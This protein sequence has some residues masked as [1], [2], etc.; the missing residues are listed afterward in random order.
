[1]IEIQDLRGLA[2]AAS[3]YNREDTRHAVQKILTPV[4]SRLS[5][6][7][8]AQ[9]VELDGYVKAVQSIQEQREEHRKVNRELRNRMD[10]L[11]A[12]ARELQEQLANQAA[13]LELEVKDKITLE[14]RAVDL[15]SHRDTLAATIEQIKMSRSWRWTSS[16]RRLGNLKLRGSVKLSAYWSRIRVRSILIYHRLSIRNPRLAWS[17]RRM[18]RPAFRIA[19]R[20]FSHPVTMD[21][22]D[23][24]AAGILKPMQ[25]QQTEASS[26]FRPLVS[27]IVPNFNHAAYLALRLDSIFSQSYSNFEV[28]L[29]DDSSTD[30]STSILEEYQ[31]RYASKTT[32]VVNES[33]SG[34]VFK[35]WQKGLE[36]AQGDLVWMAESDDWCSANFL[37]ALVPYFEN[38]AIQL[39]YTRTVFMDAEG[40]QQIWSINDYLHDIDAHRWNHEIIETGPQIVKQAFAQKNIIPNVSSALFRNPRH[41]ALLSDPAW[42]GMSICGDWIFYLHLIRGGMIAYTPAACNYYRIHGKN[43]SVAAH[44]ADEFYREHQTVAETLARYYDPGAGALE[45]LRDHLIVHWR[46]TRPRDPVEGL[47]RCFDLKEIQSHSNPRPPNLLMVSY[48]F[49]TGGGETFPVSLANLMKGRGYNVTYLDCAREPRNEGVRQRL[50]SDIPIVS[51]F[52]QLENIVRN[53]EIDVIHS[54]HAWADSTVLD[55]LPDSLGCKTVV[56]LHGMYETI[57]ELD[58]KVIL[59]RL[60]QRSSRL[61]YV[62]DKNLSAIDRMGLLQ[63]ARIE[64]IDNALED[65]PYEQIHRAELDIPEG[66]FVLALVSRAMEEKGWAEGIQAVSS[67]RNASGK[68]IHLLL[69]GDGPEYERL[70]SESLP[71]YVHLEGFQ[72]NVR[73]YFALSDVGFLPSRFKGES[74]PLVIIE[75]L[76]AGRPVLATRLGEIPYMLDSDRG[77]A[78]VLVDLDGDDVDIPAFAEVISRLAG[79]CSEYRVLH[80]LVGAAAAKFDPKLLAQRHDAAYRSVMQEAR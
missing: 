64:R 15:E 59:P 56:T 45:Q 30:E 31:R 41:L 4:F 5:D 68:D 21:S 69:V 75:C 72:H 33:N 50:R 80:S 76:K 44:T 48:G 60:V 25:Y 16:M 23:S 17:L 67:A 14:H 27:V 10:E 35:Q 8:R 70:L 47:D 65:E 26:N 49:C 19:T 34:G 66:A 9:R 51:D 28:I 2:K 57:N 62:A 11:Q 40:D 74:F 55:L 18:L 1:M 61:I 43:T 12:D 38:E 54:H 7:Y 36:A 24:C 3:D 71:D 79:S 63:Q 42:Q 6:D 52:P 77:P 29:L 58:L 53:F 22:S 20:V 37:E 78:G 32:L 13:A 73:G 46:E 39:A